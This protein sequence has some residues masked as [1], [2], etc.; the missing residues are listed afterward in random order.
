MSGLSQVESSRAPAAIG[1]YSQAVRVG[2][3]VFVSGQ[4]PLDPTTGMLVEGDLSRQM[5]R[6]L[7]NIGAILASAGSGFEQVV[8]STLYLVDMNDFTTVNEVYARCF[9]PP[10]PARATVGVAALPKGARVE[11][12]VV[13]HIQYESAG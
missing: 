12:D 6:V 11:M 10:Y 3:W 5:E 2:E 13:A 8:K 9:K 4:I 7:E 1:P